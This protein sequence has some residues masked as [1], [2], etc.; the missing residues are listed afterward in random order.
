VANAD[1][2]KA[3]ADDM[4]K[5]YKDR[6]GRISSIKAETH[7]LMRQAK[8][9]D[10][11]RAKAVDD[12]QADTQK[13]IGG[14]HRDS[15]ARAA[16]NAKMMAGFRRDDKARAEEVD[17]LQAETQTMVNA[18]RR[19]HH[20]TAAA[21]RGLVATMATTRAPR[22]PTAMVEAKGKRRRRRKKR[23]G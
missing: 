14:F 22:V 19:E 12:L 7:G 21:W 17:E 16:D 2:F 1:D 20:A 3:L 6:T 10:K 11:T 23:G 15:K 5:A 18:F 8:E 13:M 9:E 4:A